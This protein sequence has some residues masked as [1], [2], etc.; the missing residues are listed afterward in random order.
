ML[1]LTRRVGESIIINND[2]EV[3]ILDVKG[4]QIKVGINA[5]KTVPIYRKE[6]FNQIKEENESAMIDASRLEDL[7][8]L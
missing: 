7:K 2:V 5:P 4:D 6:I 1:A 8:G 3:T